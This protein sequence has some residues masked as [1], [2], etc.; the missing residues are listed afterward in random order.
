MFF[1][2]DGRWGRVAS[3]CH[4]ACCWNL[5]GSSQLSVGCLFLL[6]EG[7]VEPL[8]RCD[9]MWWGGGR[10]VGRRVFTT[11]AV[12]FSVAWWK[13]PECVHCIFAINKDAWKRVSILFLFFYLITLLIFFIFYLI[14]LLI[15]YIYLVSLLI[16]YFLSR[17]S[18]CRV[19]LNEDEDVN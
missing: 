1:I 14:T 13:W 4:V 12:C 5:Y 11:V 15:V 17:P 18:H 10:G 16:V 7:V 2:I 8:L 6:L 3:P 19:Q 9:A